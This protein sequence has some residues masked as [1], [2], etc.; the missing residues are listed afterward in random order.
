M[1]RFYLIIILDAEP[2]QKVIDAIDQMTFKVPIAT[3]VE[4]GWEERKDETNRVIL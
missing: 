4:P 1:V 3:L 2:L